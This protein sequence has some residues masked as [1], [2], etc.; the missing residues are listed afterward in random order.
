M[1]SATVFTFK[2]FRGT[3]NSAGIV[4]NDAGDHAGRT[5]HTQET[6]A[7]LVTNAIWL[8][9]PFPE[10]TPNQYILLEALRLLPLLARRNPDFWDG[11]DAYLPQRWAGVDLMRG[12]GFGVDPRQ[13][14]A[15]V[16]LDGLLDVKV[17]VAR[18]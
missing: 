8:A 7:A 10:D 15:R 2:P 3:D 1:A 14:V 5:P 13:T 16:P 6:V 17:K 11:S 12:G 18:T 4:G 9:A